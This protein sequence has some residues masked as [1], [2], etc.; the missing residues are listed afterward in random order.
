MLKQAQA[1]NAIGLKNLGGAKDTLTNLSVSP[2]GPT[3]FNPAISSGVQVAGQ[4][5]LQNSFTPAISSINTQMENENANLGNINAIANTELTALKPEALNPG[6]TLTTAG[7]TPLLRTPNYQ[8]PQIRPDTGTLDSFDAANGMWKSDEEGGGTAG[9]KVTPAPVATSTGTVD[10]TGSSAG[11]P[12]YAADPSQASAVNATFTSLSKAMPTPSADALDQ[13]IAGHAKGSP[14]TGQMLMGVASQVG[15]DPLYLA[16]LLQHETDFGTSGE[17]SENNNPGGVKFVGAPGTT[18]G[19]AAPEGGNYAKFNSWQQGVIAAANTV[20]KYQ[21]DPSNPPSSTA[22]TDPKGNTFNSAYQSRVAQLLPSL[23]PYTLAGPDGVAYIDGDTAKTAG[24]DQAAAVSG[25]K[26][27]VPVL[28]SDGVSAMNNMNL[29]IQSVQQMKSL[30]TK[31]LG[32]QDNSTMGHIL[33]SFGAGV[34]HIAQ[35]QPDLTAMESYIGSVTTAANN[36]KTLAGGQ[37]SGL[38]ITGFEI[39]AVGDT[40]PTASDS[41]QEAQAK[42]SALDTKI[43]QWM[44][45]NFPD[46]PVTQVASPQSQSASATPSTASTGGGS[47]IQ[48]STFMGITLPN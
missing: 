10:L 21:G 4:G 32:T 41:W 38:R 2:N 12:P 13:Y 39:G 36:L 16:S 22:T 26:T 1:Q 25:S 6:Q 28:T 27:G 31:N 40:L 9:S 14:I 11:Q 42:I 17:A 37:G 20:A 43:S 15:I 45:T 19:T 5:E 44:N 18:Q 29:L 3:S 33:N 47:A 46:V 48:G 35:N 34:N 7:G 30:V 23:K 24:L 8:P